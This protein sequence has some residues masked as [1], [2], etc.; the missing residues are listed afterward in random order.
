VRAS[1][2]REAA[3]GLGAYAAYLAVGRRVATPVGQAKAR[4][5]ALRV[6]AVE[7]RLG[8][9]VEPRVQAAALRAPTL[10]H[11]LNA[12]YAAAN[13]TLSV[14]LLVWLYRRRDPAFSRE[15]RAAVA[16]F[17]GA[18]PVFALVPTAPPRTLDGYV[19]TIARSGVDIEHPLLMRFYNP[20]AALPSHHV[21]FAVV[22]GEAIAARSRRPAW[23]LYPVAVAGVVIATGN[24]FLL[25]CVAGA[26]LGAVA[27]RSTR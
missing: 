4:R 8:V 11:V 16:A 3:V 19:D 18:L 23:R 17:L 9:A 2:L 20:V 24:H 27:R 13:V 5:N 7:R 1:T 26:A 6:V 14:G 25:D 21:A 22:T 15:R 12:G 10:V